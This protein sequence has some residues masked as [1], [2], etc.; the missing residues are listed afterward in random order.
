MEKKDIVDAVNEVL[1]SR[2]DKNIEHKE[3]HA[4][5]R[6]LIEERRRRQDRWEKIRTQLWGWAIISAIA[7]F[8]GAL[9]YAAAQWVKSNHG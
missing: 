1:D 8:L 6:M 5:I 4:F 2:Q 9:G 7:S 3:H